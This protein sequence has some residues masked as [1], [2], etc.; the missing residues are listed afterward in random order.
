LKISIKERY[1]IPGRNCK[2]KLPRPLKIPAE[3][4]SIDV[5]VEQ[6]FVSKKALRRDTVL[7]G[8]LVCFDIA[9]SLNRGFLTNNCKIPISE[10]FKI[11]IILNKRAHINKSFVKN[12]LKKNKSDI[13]TTK[14]EHLLELHKNG[15]N[16]YKGNFQK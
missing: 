6:T 4:K 13:K 16:V 14:K 9:E 2:I 3:T 12:R 7:M 11:A 1:V 5:N 10:G 8:I 15:R